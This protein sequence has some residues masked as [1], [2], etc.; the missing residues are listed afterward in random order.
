[1]TSQ[2]KKKYKS[3]KAKSIDTYE[4]SESHLG[5]KFSHL[6]KLKHSTIQRISLP[7]QKLSS[8]EELDLQNINQQKNHMINEKCTQKWLI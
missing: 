7:H 2:K 4:F 3:Y 5:Y 6:Y 8:M 1:M